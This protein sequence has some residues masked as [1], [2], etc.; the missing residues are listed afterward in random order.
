MSDNFNFYCYSFKL[1]HFLCAFGESC[2]LTKINPTSGNRYWVFTKSKRL[3]EIIELYN[4][5]KHKIS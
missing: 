2:K 1:Y 3:D 4:N 5:V